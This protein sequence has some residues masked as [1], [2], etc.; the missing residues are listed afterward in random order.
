MKTER[1]IPLEKSIVRDIIK[2]LN[3]LPECRARKVPGN[4]RISGEPDIDA[5]L[6][7]K[8]LKLEVKRPEPYGSPVTALQAAT[9]AKWAAVGAI[10]GVV[11]SVQ[12]VKELI[13]DVCKP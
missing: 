10:T 7:G 12:D 8:S 13:K 9:L 11:R 5:V 3:S 1:A 6:N 4:E 2:Y